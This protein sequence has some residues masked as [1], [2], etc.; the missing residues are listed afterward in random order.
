MLVKWYNH[1]YR[2][3]FKVSMVYEWDKNF[4]LEKSVVLDKIIG[5]IH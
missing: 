2:I 4:N 1:H 5:L 3:I